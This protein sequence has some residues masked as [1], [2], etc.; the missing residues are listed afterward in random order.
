MPSGTKNVD[1]AKGNTAPTPLSELWGQSLPQL[2]PGSCTLQRALQGKEEHTV[3][4]TQQ[5]AVFTSLWLALS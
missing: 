1:T 2:S 5:L 4:A 3:G